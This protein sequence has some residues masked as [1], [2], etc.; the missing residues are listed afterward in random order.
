MP[1]DGT[2]EAAND[3]DDS[4]EWTES[5]YEALSAEERERVQQLRPP[6]VDGELII[7]RL[8]SAMDTL[9]REQAARGA[10]Y[11]TP[12]REVAS[13]PPPPP[14]PTDVWLPTADESGKVYFFNRLTGETSWTRPEAK[15]LD[16]GPGHEGT[17]V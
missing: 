7:G 5:V 4:D 2:V 15:E 14:A 17:A 3:G 6:A 8:T 16:G 13:P 10:D 1:A 12:E 11:E 9:A